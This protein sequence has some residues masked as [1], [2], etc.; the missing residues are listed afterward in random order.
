[1]NTYFHYRIET[2]TMRLFW[3]GLFSLTMVVGISQKYPENTFIP[4][5]DIPIV[6]AGTFGELRSNHFHGGIDIKTQQRQG[7]PIYAIGDGIVTRIKI[8]HW[9]Y[10]KAIYVAHPNGYT[11]VYGHLKRFNPE[12]EKYIKALQ[13]D[14]QKYEVEVFPDY[15]ELSLKQGDVI[16]Y[17]GN[18][19]SSSGPHLHFEIRTSL[20]SKPTNP[21]FY[22]YEVRDGTTLVGLFAYPL[23][24]QAQVNQSANKVKL[25]Y[26]RQADGSLAD[27][28]KALGEIGFG[29]M[30]MTAKIWPPI[31]MEST[32][33]TVD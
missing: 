17:S 7:L 11:S 30:G 33:K 20:N 28:V 3:L 27:K 29:L 8:A 24:E 14:K 2:I 18:S 25:N 9:G 26:T 32:L 22:G 15:G 19:G 12:I 31:K 5:V 23:G 6:L 13:Y 16:A 10:G 1:M 21:L 4:P